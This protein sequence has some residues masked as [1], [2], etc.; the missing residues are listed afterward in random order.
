MHLENLISFGGYLRLSVGYSK[1]FLCE[2]GLEARMFA[3]SF[4][5]FGDE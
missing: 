3:V 2:V 4:S 1:N 5:C